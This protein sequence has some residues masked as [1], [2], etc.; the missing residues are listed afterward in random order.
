MEGCCIARV[1]G[2]LQVD[3][4]VDLAAFG[5]VLNGQGIFVADGQRLFHHYVNAQCGA[6]FDH[7]PMLTWSGEDEHCPRMG[8]R[9]HFLNAVKVQAR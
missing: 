3:E 9:N 8:L 6:L 1:P 2:R 5:G 7:S 4:H